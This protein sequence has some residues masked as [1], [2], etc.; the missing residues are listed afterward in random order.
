MVKTYREL[1]KEM[2]EFLDESCVENSDFDC[3]ELLGKVLGDDCRSDRYRKRLDDLSDGK[4]RDEFI[5]LC[6]RRAEG[7]PLQYL[8]GEWE[9]Y[10]YPFKVGKGVLIPRQDT[11]TLIDVVLKKFGSKSELTV[12]DLCSGTGCI[13]VALEKNLK[14][15]KVFCVEKS[16]EAFGYLE[17]NIRLNNS[18]AKAVLADV[19]DE[20]VMKEFPS[21]DIIVSNP[22]YINGND[23]KE[24]QKEV[25]YEP[26]MALFGG[27]DGL[28]FYRSITR[29]WKDKLKQGGMLVFEVGISQED[30]VMRILIQHGFENVRCRPDLCG[31]NRCVFGFKP[32]E[33]N[34]IAVKVDYDK[35]AHKNF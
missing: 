30:D 12:I 28:D 8:I 21:A 7:E 29:V 13:G 9:F 10:G 20:N 25:R 2:T 19:L 16:Q 22:P 27:D 32:F 14:C 31:V 17:E 4:L 3:A 26:E 5:S 34:E 11:E 24:L 33:N 1:L 35:A 6:K 23:M 18:T 15:D